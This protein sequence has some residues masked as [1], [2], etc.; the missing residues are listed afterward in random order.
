MDADGVSLIQ[1]GPRPSLRLRREN[2]SVRAPLRHSDAPDLE[3]EPIP[4]FEMMDAA[5]GR[6]RLS[7]HPFAFARFFPVFDRSRTVR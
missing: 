6:S 4:I 5:I 7:C 2:Q 3:F 1:T